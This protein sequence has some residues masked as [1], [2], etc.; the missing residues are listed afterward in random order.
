M[1]CRIGRNRAASSKQRETDCVGFAGN[2]RDSQRIRLVGRTDLG[3]EVGARAAQA[4]ERVQGSERRHLKRHLT[5]AQTTT[6][7]LSP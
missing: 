5:R 1:R 2:G 6:R 3:I 4:I 7:P